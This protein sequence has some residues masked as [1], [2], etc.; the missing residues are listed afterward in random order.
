M[1]VPGIYKGYIGLD[2]CNIGICLS[3]SISIYIYMYKCVYMYIRMGYVGVYKTCKWRVVPVIEVVKWTRTQA[4][5]F[6]LKILN[7]EV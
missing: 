7:V 3:I 1:E 6:W 5:S 2:R 4:S